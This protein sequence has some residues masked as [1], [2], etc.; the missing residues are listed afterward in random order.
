LKSCRNDIDRFTS[1]F[2]PKGERDGTESSPFTE[3]ERDKI[4]DYFKAKR[5]RGAAST[6]PDPTIRTSP[7]STRSSSPACG[8]VVARIG[9][10][11]IHARTLQVERSRHLGTEAA[12]K[13]QR[14]RRTVRL[15]PGKVEVL[16]PLIELKARPHDYLFKN[17]RG[18]P[19]EASNFY[20]L[21]R[22]AQRALSISPLRDLCST[23]DTYISLA[24]TN[25]V[26]VTW[27]SEQSG[28]ALTTILKH[29]GKFIH[30]SQ[31]D[32]LEMSK[33]EVRKGPEKVQIGH[34]KV[35][36]KKMP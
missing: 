10:L 2:E 32:D 5:W 30:S 33:I 17:V 25:A 8:L 28:V 22:D 15:T 34:Q 21:F 36:R 26:S 24:L 14:A 3:R 4:L 13:T 1:D 31:A 11:N 12:P 23:K 27:L 7:S 29:Y 35:G 9:S 20:D 19:I 6:I 16:Q 18:K